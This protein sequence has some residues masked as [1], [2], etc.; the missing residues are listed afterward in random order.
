MQK[1]RQVQFTVEGYFYKNRDY[2][3]KL[4]FL[5]EISES[6][7]LR[8]AVEEARK[9][10]TDQL[11]ENYYHLRN[12]RDELERELRQLKSKVAVARKQWE[13]TQQFLVAQ[14]IKTDVTGFPDFNN[15]LLP[16][17][18]ET[19]DAEIEDESDDDGVS[20]DSRSI[21]DI[22]FDQGSND[23]PDPL[24]HFCSPSE[25]PR[26]ATANPN[27]YKRD[28]NQRIPNL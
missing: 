8:Q 13:N 28:W 19:V 25:I 15:Y 7:T 27:G 18:T 9:E 11:G 16:S 1:V 12:Q 6:K 10:L 24:R 17:N 4:T 5:L 26:P 21:N 3:E 20:E 22:P 14:G 2:P 23:D